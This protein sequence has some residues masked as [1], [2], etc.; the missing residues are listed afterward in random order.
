MGWEGWFSWF[1]EEKGNC[2]GRTKLNLHLWSTYC[3][4]RPV[5]VSGDANILCLLHG[6]SPG[7]PKLSTY[8][9]TGL[10][11]TARAPGLC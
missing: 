1:S 10:V 4:S 8:G 5:L 6:P 3:V 2:R 9:D 11:G 7:L